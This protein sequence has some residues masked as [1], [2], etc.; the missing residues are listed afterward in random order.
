MEEEVLRGATDTLRR[1]QPMVYVEYIRHQPSL[2]QH[3]TDLGY[4]IQRHAPPLFAPNNFARNPS[5]VFGNI[6]SKNLIATPPRRV[7]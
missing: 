3:L 2:L 6:V 5:N 7:G 4:R 1:C